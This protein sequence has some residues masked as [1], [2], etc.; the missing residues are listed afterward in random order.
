MKILFD[1]LAKNKITPNGLLVL[2]A[3]YHK[4]TYT[5]FINFKHEQHRL[6]LSGFLSTDIDG[7]NRTIYKITQEGLHII[8]DAN[9]IMNKMKTAKKKLSI[10]FSDWENQIKQYNE[11]FPK[12]KK[13]GT[14]IP[15][16]ANPKE[17]FERFKWFFI[18]YSEYSWDDVLYA[19]RAYAKTYEEENEYTYMQNSKYFIKKTDNTKTVTSNLATLCYNIANGDN[20]EMDT[21]TF[22]FGP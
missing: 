19:T 10:P 2:D 12:G 18:E 21:G 5:K 22:Y 7:D 14:A 15:F 6:N 13:S 4:Y 16:R 20:E 3:I 1:F 11:L 8:R 9:K 17:L